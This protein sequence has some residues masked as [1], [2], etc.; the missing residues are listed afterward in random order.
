MYVR[1]CDKCKIII[2]GEYADLRG[3]IWTKN[4][5]WAKD[6]DLHLCSKCMINFEKWLKMED[7]NGGMGNN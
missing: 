3:T 4:G 7:E 1:Q 6:I 5:T 2:K